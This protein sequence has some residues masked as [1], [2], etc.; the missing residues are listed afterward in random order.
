MHIFL[1]YFYRIC[2]Y[3]I[4][5]SR[6]LDIIIIIIIMDIHQDIIITIIKDSHRDIIIKDIR[7]A[8]VIKDSLA[9]VKGSLAIVKDNLVLKMKNCLKELK[10]K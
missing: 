7:L 4:S 6:H 3:Q 10:E 2:Y 5:I 1:K 9:I 8:I